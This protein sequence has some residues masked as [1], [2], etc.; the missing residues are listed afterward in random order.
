MYSDIHRSQASRRYPW[1]VHYKNQDKSAGSSATVRTCLWRRLDSPQCLTDKHWRRLD[2]RITPSGRSVN[3]YSTRSLF[4]KS[5]LFGK[6]LQ[7]VWTTRQHV[8]T[9]YSICKPS[10][11][12]NNTSGRYLVV[13]I[14]SRFPFERGND[15]SKDRPDARSSRP[16]ANLIRIELRC[17]WRISQKSVRTWQISVRTLDKQSPNLSS[18]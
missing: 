13:Q 6:S 15:F 14:N 8:R 12:L 5:T 18:F 11:R 7:S 3:Q 4:S 1:R 2:V 16:D 10:E 17:F 9:M